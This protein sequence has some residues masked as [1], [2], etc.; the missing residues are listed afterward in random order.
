MAGAF[1]AALAA[2]LWV[3]SPWQTVSPPTRM[4]LSLSRDDSLIVA[5]GPAISPDGGTVAFAALSDAGSNLY[6]RRFEDWE[7]RALP[8]TAGATSPFFS[9]DGRWIA[10]ARRKRLEKVPASG[11]PPQVIHEARA[12]SDL[13]GGHWRRDGTIVFGT[14]PGGLWRVSSDGGMPEPLVAPPE[15]AGAMYLSPQ[16]LPD[17]SGILFTIWYQGQK[18]IAVLP[19]GEDK[20]RVLVKSGDRARYVPTGHLVYVSNGRLLAVP[21]DP[22]RLEIGGGETVVAEDMGDSS[23]TFDYDVSATGTLVYRPG[24][25]SARWMI[26]RSTSVYRCAITT[27]P[28]ARLHAAS[29]TPRSG[30]RARQQTPASRQA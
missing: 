9:P 1:G 6:V 23:N 21:F 26:M 3:A 28:A 12:A 22:Q 18:S 14:W 15:G 8:Q 19:R 4:T 16:E 13:F 2:A 30:S 29:R 10:F 5:G 11:G 27:L 7:P 25:A 20:P 17:E 24:S